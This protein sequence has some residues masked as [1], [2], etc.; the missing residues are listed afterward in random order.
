MKIGIALGGGGAKGMAHIGVLRVLE[1][2]R[3]QIDL[4]AGTSAGAIAGA[5]Y[6]AG[7]SPDEIAARMRQ[8]RLSQLLTRDR[9]GWGLFSTDGIRRV[10]ETEIGQTT[11]IEHLPRAFVAVAVDMNSGDEIAFDAGSVADAVCASAAFPGL[12]APVQING[13]C[14]FDGGVTNPVPFD[15]VRQR[16]A[17]RV[18]AVDLGADDPV[19]TVAL[20]HRRHGE[21]IYRLLWAAE[22]QQVVRVASRAIGIMSRQMRMQKLKQSP[23]DVVIAPQVQQVGMLD[24][25]LAAEC[26]HAGEQAARDVLPQIERVVKSPAWWYGAYRWIV[27]IRGRSV[28]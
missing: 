11:R 22:S 2:A 26:I 1:A 10:I 3:V 28:S 8:L 24:L 16:G 4:V 23:P 20:P 5:L 18:L 7:K 9:T 27:R 21:L 25:D 13:R 14:Y 17:D 12:F 6:A 15:V 19:F